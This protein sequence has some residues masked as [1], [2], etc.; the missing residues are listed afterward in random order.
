M[1]CCRCAPSAEDFARISAALKA[2][3]SE[4]RHNLDLA[5]TKTKGNVRVERLISIRFRGQ[6]HHLDVPLANDAFDLDAF[7]KAV[8]HFERE[9]E[10]L[11]GRG[12]AFSKAGYELLSVRAVGIGALPPPAVATKGEKLI[13]VKSRPVIFRDP[14]A[15]LETA[16]YKTTYP[17]ADATVEGPAII[18]FP[19]QSVVVPPKAKATADRFGNLHVRPL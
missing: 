2:T 12:A 9:Y 4:V 13:L 14:K 7:R 17:E 18:E 10:T 15:P 8:A 5:L 16:I 6:T 11:F 3:A 19:G 1:S